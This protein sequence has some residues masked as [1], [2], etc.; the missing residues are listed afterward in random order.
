[1]D[2]YFMSFAYFVVFILF[3]YLLSIYSTNMNL[4]FFDKNLF[5]ICGYVNHIVLKNTEFLVTFYRRNDLIWV[6]GFLLD[7]LQKKSADIWLRK[8][9][10]YSGFLFS[11]RLVFEHVVRVYLINIIWPLHYV[12]FFETNNTSEMLSIIVFFYFFMF[13][14]VFF[15][16]LLFL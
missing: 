8:F 14:I 11:E 7:F 5:L 13:S 1:M 3:L 2:F 15:L 9:V 10:I 4:K 16:F 12:G 6:D